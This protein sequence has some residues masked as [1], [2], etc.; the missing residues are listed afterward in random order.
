[1]MMMM[2]VVV[3][4][5]VVVSRTCIHDTYGAARSVRYVTILESGGGRLSASSATCDQLMSRAS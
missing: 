2:V 3:V 5:M 1:M 4:V